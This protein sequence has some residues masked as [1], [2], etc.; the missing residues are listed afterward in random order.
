M[1]RQ[2]KNKR[3]GFTLVELLVVIAIIV[4]LAAMTTPA[5]FKALKKAEQT[6][7][8]NNLKDIHKSMT[9][10][11]MDNDG[12]FPSEELSGEYG[13]SSGD[14]SNKLFA[15]LFAAKLIDSEYE[16]LFWVKGGQTCSKKEP[17][18]ITTQDKRFSE[19]KTLQPGDV[20]Y[21]YVAEQTNTDNSGRPL[22][23]DSPPS[24]SGFDFDEEL[25]SG[26]VMIL[27]IGGDVKAEKLDMATGKLLDGEKKELF[28]VSAE[29]W[30]NKEHLDV[31]YPEMK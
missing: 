11:G 31:A 12:L 16:N 30:G 29:V 25:R 28:N 15:Q 19:Q 21:A 1:N 2:T 18:G 6:T 10:F 13:I 17:D 9:M 26:K 7:S 22:I 27:R 3:A 24:A 20:G 8:I 5:V 14:S 23:F 4:G